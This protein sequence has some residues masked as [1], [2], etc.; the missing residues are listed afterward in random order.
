MT[1]GQTGTPPA[2]T[3]LTGEQLHRVGQRIWQNECGGT[4]AGLT[5]WNAGEDFA[6]LGIGHFIWYPAGKRGP[7]EESFPPLL[8]HLRRSGVVLPEWL[9]IVG[10]CPWPSRS[11]FLADAN[12]ARQQQLRTLLSQTV[13]QQTDF[14]AARMRASL[15]K[16]LAAAPASQRAQ[17]QN[18]FNALQATPEG[19]FC[20]I[21]Y[22]NFKGEGVSP[23]ER[24]NGQGWGLLQVLAGMTAD[25]TAAAAFAESA[26][27][28]LTNR[29][30]NAPPS[31][32]E[33]RWLP[34]WL[35]RCEAYKRPL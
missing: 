7:F 21:D 26:K 32:G 24:Y 31:R 35:N 12:G 22:V 30:R 4:V 23:S 27:R 20:L 34:G 2:A 19:T 6:S 10:P 28:V 15:P 5:S 33:S 13:A 8:A 14:I 11:A 18:S 1:S 29:V 3:R 9:H 16:M 17:V 25:R